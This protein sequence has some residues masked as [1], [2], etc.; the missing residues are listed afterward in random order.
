MRLTSA[1][2]RKITRTIRPWKTEGCAVYE[3]PNARRWAWVVLFTSSS[4]LICCALPI[5]FVSVG[6]G[7]VS[8][9]LFASFPF[10][11][12]LSQFKTW[13]FAGSAA[14]LVLTAWLLYRPG[15]VC[16]ADPDLALKCENAHRWNTRYFWL[17]TVIWTVGLAA[18]Y[19][20]L[21]IYIWLEK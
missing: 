17:A 14:V 13:M 19:L 9:S 16:P 4:T 20:A 3:P 7:T 8:A 21:P 2:S 10:L 6:L 11:V 12:T 5:L 15:R 18:A 1:T